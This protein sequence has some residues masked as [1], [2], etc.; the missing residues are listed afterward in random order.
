MPEVTAP[1]KRVRR[2]RLILVLL[3]LL[4]LVISALF[5][6][7]PADTKMVWLTPAAVQEAAKPG[8][9][10]TAWYRFRRMIGPLNRLLPASQKARL[11][12]DSSIYSLTN[13]PFDLG[14]PTAT[15][16]NGMCAWIIPP[17][18]LQSFRAQLKSLPPDALLGSPRM[19]TSDGIRSQMSI[20][21]SIVVGGKIVPVG[22]IVDLFPK[23]SKNSIRLVVSVVDSQTE[24]SSIKTN[25]AVGCAATVPD[26]GALVIDAGGA[27][28]GRHWMV[29]SPVLVD[30]T[31]VPLKH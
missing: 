23:I 14:A 27:G 5:L 30:A 7:P 28:E 6:F 26:G 25:F 12:F 13:A 1:T 3:T 29:L 10:K 16:T 20:G 19:Q 18:S 15:S 31:G 9:L 21:S 22:L 17:S 4:V 11:R 2:F 8:P 24:A